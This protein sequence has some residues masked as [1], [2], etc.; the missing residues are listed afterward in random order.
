[1]W[2]CSTRVT[3][4][5]THRVSTPAFVGGVYNDTC[6]DESPLLKLI[7]QDDPP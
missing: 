3:R 6:R 7:K 1:M 4:P 5:L 2:V